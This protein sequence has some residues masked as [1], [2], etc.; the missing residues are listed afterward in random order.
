MVGEPEKPG[1]WFV[2]PNSIEAGGEG[3]APA[4]MFF[5]SAINGGHHFRENLGM[6]AGESRE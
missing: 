5:E 1:S 6:G 2:L 4:A 3:V